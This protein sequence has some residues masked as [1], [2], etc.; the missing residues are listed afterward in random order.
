[1][2]K[3]PCIII[4]ALALANSLFVPVFGWLS[5]GLFPKIYTNGI[6]AIYILVKAYK[7]AFSIHFYVIFFVIIFAFMVLSIL[8][9]VASFI[10]NKVL[11]AISS[12]LG[13]AAWI[14]ATIYIINR[15]SKSVF[16]PDNGLIA[17]GYYL[18]IVLFIA[19]FI[20]A[21]AV[22][23]KPKKAGFY[24]PAQQPFYYN[25]PTQQPYSQPVSQQPYFDDNQNMQ[26]Q[27]NNQPEQNSFFINPTMQEPAY[28]TPA[29]NPVIE[30]PEEPQQADADS[31]EEQ[32]K[33]CPTCGKII[34]ASKKFCGKCGTK[35]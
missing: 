12:G 30:I 13:I 2:K 20:V 15:F 14:G 9:F 35:L 19:Y 10:G 4:A 31:S 27:Y 6:Y 34:D 18:A 11:S 8:I 22:N 1:M 3:L 25:Q 5:G 28:N 33:V 23:T 32:T 7:Y 16:D 29:S 21:L 24:P 17:I 26:N